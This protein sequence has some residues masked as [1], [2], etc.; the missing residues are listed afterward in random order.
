MGEDKTLILWIFFFSLLGSVGAIIT[1]AIFL[2][3][4]EKMQKTLIPCLISYAIGTLLTTALLGLIPHALNHATSF[5]VLSSVL[6]GIILFFLLEKLLVWRH[7]HNMECEVHGAVGPMLLL[8]DAFHNL[9]D[10]VV[11]AASFLSSTPIGIVTSLTVL[12]HEIPQE[13]GDFAILLANGYSKRKALLWNILS[14]LST[15]PGAIL[16]YYALEIIRAAIPY[17]LAISAAS[18]LYISLADLAPG[19]HRNV[20]FGYSIRQFLLMLLGVGT[21]IL[22]LRSHP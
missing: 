8:G 18:F 1:A 17:A 15:L 22:F 10:G 21:I 5:S 12:A 7:C 20:G 3:I 6:T 19:L 9:T 13:L 16:A 11:I 14:S 2:S 4:P